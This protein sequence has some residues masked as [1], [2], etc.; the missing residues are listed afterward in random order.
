MKIFRII[1]LFLISFWASNQLLA[2]NIYNLDKI[3][4]VELSFKDENWQVLLEQLK[5]NG[6]ERLE[7]DLVVNG[8]TYKSVGVRYKGN[9]SFFNTRS[10]GLEKLPFNIKTDF[11]I[12]DQKIEGKYNRLKL[13]NVFADPSFI[14]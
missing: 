4:N 12:K 2:Q 14:R 13:S 9:S 8:V 7:A 6:K 3:T 1:P 5:L 11:K 10:K